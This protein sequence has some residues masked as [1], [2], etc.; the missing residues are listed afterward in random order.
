MR[1]IAK[2]SHKPQSAS[3]APL[4]IKAVIYEDETGGFVAEVPA[5]PGCVTQGDTREELLASLREAVQGCLLTT[6]GNYQP[7]DQG[8][9]EEVEL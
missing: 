6:P 7:M 1:E 4:K 8:R 3:G 5:L 2:R 9:E